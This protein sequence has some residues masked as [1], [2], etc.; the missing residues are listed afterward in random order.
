MTVQEMIDFFSKVP[1]KSKEVKVKADAVH[2]P[3]RPIKH[4][5]VFGK[6]VIIYPKDGI[7]MYEDSRRKQ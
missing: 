3:I 7:E 6:D 2:W 4:A 1:D 5:I